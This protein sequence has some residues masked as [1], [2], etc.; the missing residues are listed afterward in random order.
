LA[1]PPSKWVLNEG[2]DA[3]CACGVLLVRRDD[4]VARHSREQVIIVHRGQHPSLRGALVLVATVVTM[5][6]MATMAMATREVAFPRRSDA[7][8]M[9][10]GD[11]AGVCAADNAGA[12]QFT[13]TQAALW[14]GMKA[15]A[16]LGPLRYL[17]DGERGQQWSTHLCLLY[18]LTL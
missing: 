17:E 10:D 4:E 12:E 13:C 7:T 14:G 8:A 1:P 6:V 2:A 11:K 15:Q 5:M 18:I 3:V 9:C 16:L